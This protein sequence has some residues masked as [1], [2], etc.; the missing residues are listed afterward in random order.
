[1][2]DVRIYLFG[3]FC[4]EC[5][6]QLMTGL[7]AGGK[8]QELLCYLLLHRGHPQPREMLADILWSDAPGFQSKKHLRQLLW[9]LNAALHAYSAATAD[10]LVL[11]EPTWVHV[12]P[13]A[14]LWIDVATF[15]LACNNTRGVD[16]R[17]LDACQAQALREAAELFRRGD[18]LE[19]GYQ[20]WCLLERE[21]LHDMYLASLDKLMD[22]FEAH[23]DYET[24]LLH[25]IQILQYEPAR[26]STHRRLMRLHFLAG[27]RTAALQQYERCVETLLRELAVKP[28]PSTVALFEQIR[29]GSLVDPRATSQTID[30]L[31]RIQSMLADIQME[32]QHEVQSLELKRRS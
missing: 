16:G 8:L 21:R 20:D 27:D 18:L 23:G 26:E 12:N 7:N 2:N 24:A 14:D 10:R 29:D 25:G 3:R 22:Y 30:R 6:G 11:V 15:E 5:S 13:R 1:M 9:Q 32:L 28:A 19:G 17:A 4:A 31:K